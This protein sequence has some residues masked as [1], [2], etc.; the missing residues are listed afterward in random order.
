M[1]IREKWDEER[2]ELIEKYQRQFET[3]KQESYDLMFRI[4]RAKQFN[5]WGTLHKIFSVV[6]LYG[7]PYWSDYELAPLIIEN[8]LLTV[9]LMLI[10][11]EIIKELK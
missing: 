4:N 6:F 8:L 7:I 2:K 1:N 10:I 11:K 5:N 3:Y 9:K